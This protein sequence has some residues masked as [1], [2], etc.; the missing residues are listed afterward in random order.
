MLRFA[1]LCWTPFDPQVRGRRFRDRR[2][3]KFH[4]LGNGALRLA[5]SGFRSAARERKIQ[6]PR[7]TELRAINGNFFEGLN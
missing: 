3:G 4:E 5:W 1:L 2:T 7:R 6:L